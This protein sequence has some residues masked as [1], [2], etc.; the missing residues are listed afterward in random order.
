M[1][2]LWNSLLYLCPSL[3]SQ[4]CGE[5]ELQNYRGGYQKPG[6]W[7]QQTNYRG[8]SLIY[9]ICS[10]QSDYPSCFCES[11]IGPQLG[12]EIQRQLAGTLDRALHSARLLDQGMVR[13]HTLF[14]C[15]HVNARVH[16]WHE[17]SNQIGR[18]CVLFITRKE[19]KGIKK[20][21]A[22]IQVLKYVSDSIVLRVQIYL[23]RI[24]FQDRIVI[25][26]NKHTQ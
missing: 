25:C 17:I 7:E 12:A 16:I 3:A 11:A 10:C 9:T 5:R 26:A 15:E 22:N 18:D 4:L 21:D 6:W 1:Y 23:N 19:T 14:H 2:T 24:N 13:L 8:I 20:K